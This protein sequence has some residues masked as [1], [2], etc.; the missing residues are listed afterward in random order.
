MWINEKV[1]Q[2]SVPDKQVT[3]W[4]QQSQDSA[5]QPAAGLRTQV[6]KNEMAAHWEAQYAKLEQQAKQLIDTQNFGHKELA[7]RLAFIDERWA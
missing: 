2:L 7:A 3:D 1:Q 5:A 6:V 4:S